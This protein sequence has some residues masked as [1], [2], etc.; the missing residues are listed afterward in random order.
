M[1]GGVSGEVGWS[2][3]GS[4][5]THPACTQPRNHSTPVLQTAARQMAAAMTGEVSWGMGEDAIDPEDLSSVDWRVYQ[6]GQG[7][8]GRG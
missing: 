3:T 5:P 7:A 1:R 6:V 2:M 4:L 8:G